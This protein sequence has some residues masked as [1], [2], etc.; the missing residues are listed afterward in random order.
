MLDRK[1]INIYQGGNQTEAYNPHQ[2]VEFCYIEQTQ[3]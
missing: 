2:V 3:T 1:I